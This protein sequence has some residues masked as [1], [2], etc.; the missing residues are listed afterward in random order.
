[1]N[2]NY[3]NQKRV[4]ILEELQNDSKHISMNQKELIKIF[5]GNNPAFMVQ[6][7]IF[8]CLVA[9]KIVEVVDNII[10]D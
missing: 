6:A 4:R 10:A 9:Q 2:K 7:G 1:M 3:K 5:G 8:G